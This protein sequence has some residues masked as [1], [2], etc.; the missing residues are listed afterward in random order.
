[1]QLTEEYLRKFNYQVGTNDYSHTMCLIQIGEWTSDDGRKHS[2]A[3]KL[4]RDAADYDNYFAW[5]QRKQQQQQQ[6]N[7]ANTLWPAI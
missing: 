4:F 6:T 7:T 3:K 2:N 5:M 1:M